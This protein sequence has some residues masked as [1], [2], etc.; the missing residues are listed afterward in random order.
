MVT[1]SGSDRICQLGRVVNSSSHCDY[2]VQVDTAQDVATPPAEAYCGF[3]QFVALETDRRHWA[4]GIVYNSQLFNP[5]F[6]NSGPRLTGAPD[7]LFTPDL[8]QETSTL[9]N[10]VLVG[11]LVREDKRTFGCHGIPRSVV[12]VNT[13][14]YAVGEQTVHQFHLDDQA[15][16]QFRYYAH[17]LSSG[18]TFATQLTQQVLSTL[19]ASELFDPTEQQALEILCKE[20]TWKNTLGVLG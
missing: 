15:Q 13:P 10:V 16:P 1:S 11:T 17:L 20:L 7:P 12:P 18:G 14:V 5:A 9:L 19:M 6:L 4:V 3:G 2:V 8:I